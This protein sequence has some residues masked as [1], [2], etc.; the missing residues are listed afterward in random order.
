MSVATSTNQWRSV[1]LLA[2]DG[3]A[4]V[5]FYD[6]SNLVFATASSPYTSWSGKT[7]I[8]TSPGNIGEVG[9]CIDSS[10][11]LYVAYFQT[12]T[13]KPAFRLLTKS[14]TTWTVGSE[15]TVSATAMGE[16]GASILQ[17]PGG[18][19]FWL[20]CM[21]GS[22]TLYAYY[23]DNS[24]TSWTLG[25]SYAANAN[26]TTHDSNWLLGTATSSGSTYV[27][28]ACANDGTIIYRRHL[29][30]N[31]ATTWD[32]LK[33]TGTDY[34]LWKN[35]TGWSAATDATGRLML[36]ATPGTTDYAV[37]TVYY[38]AGSDTWSASTDIGS[39]VNDRSAALV[40]NG[41]DIWC[42][43]CAY[44]AANNYSLVYKKW[45]NGSGTW[46]SATTLVA[47]GTNVTF[48]GAGYGSSTL[49]VTDNTGTAS[50]WTINFVSVTLGAAL[51]ATLAGTGV[52]TPTLTASLPLASLT[53]GGAGT[54]A[55]TLSLGTALTDTLAGAGTLAGTVGLS[56]GLTTTIAG[57][58]QV[59]AVLTASF[60]L[61]VTCAGVGTLAGTVTL[62]TALSMTSTAVGT[63]AGTPAVATV[64]ATTLAGTGTLAGAFSLATALASTLTG[65]GALIGTLTAAETLASATCAGVGTLTGTVQLARPLSQ[66]IAG[67]GTLTA[68]FSLTTSLTATCAGVGILASTTTLTTGLTATLASASTLGGAAT[69]ATSLAMTCAG[70]ATLSG[71][72]T[73]TTVLTGTLVGVGTLSGTP[74]VLVVLT[75]TCVGVSQLT[76]AVVCTTV[77][78][79]TCTGAGTLAGTVTVSLA[80]MVMFAGTGQ[81]AGSLTI[82][83]VF[84]CTLAGRGSATVAMI[85]FP[86][87]SPSATWVTRDHR[88]T[89]VTRDAAAYWTTRDDAAD[90]TTRR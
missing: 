54:L 43:W 79:V 65:V 59:A 12:T 64:L 46:G 30:S 7:T 51:T 10:D 40:G 6:G 16:Q 32:T 39:S 1:P 44:S 33:T 86:G 37:R 18:S 2:S 55:E 90:W 38:T 45:S 87:V 72:V 53:I 4:C 58:G 41:T 35:H 84:S 49:G 29:T 48:L 62:A 15:V 71:T 70:A 13:L 8:S 74:T 50:P 20:A 80:F 25:I 22:G 85:S 21:D 78:T 28:L 81:I 42:F 60:S 63:L 17:E 27:V 82:G 23:S 76:G 57:N 83:G 26:F 89:W 24:G 11:K 77:L 68:P 56:T 61:T 34:G 31:T 73:L 5:V 66:T 14:G 75:T 3:T 9:V 69:L 19:R 67:M 88:A 52:L 36:A 47:A